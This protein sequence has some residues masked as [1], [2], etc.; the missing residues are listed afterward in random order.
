MSATTPEEALKDILRNNAGVAAITT[1]CYPVKIPQSPVMPLMTYTLITDVPDVH[2]QGPSGLINARYQIEAWALTYSAAKA[3]AKAID[4]AL[5]GY[6]GTSGTVKIGS[7]LRITGRD[8]YE[9]AVDCYR[10]IQDF[11]VWYAI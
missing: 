3:L 10:I 11:S 9:E 1:K 7:I 6:S 5:A 8:W 4:T 2:L